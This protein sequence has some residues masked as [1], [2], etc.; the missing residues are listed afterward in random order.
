MPEDSTQKPTPPSSSS[1]TETETPAT[2]ATPAIPTAEAAAA[3]AST[4]P[5]AAAE[6]V[7]PEGHLVNREFSV[8]WKGIDELLEAV[9]SEVF[10]TVPA[11][12][13]RI[14]TEERQDGDSDILLL[15]HTGGKWREL[16]RGKTIAETWRRLVTTR[17]PA[18]QIHRDRKRAQ[19]EQLAELQTPEPPADIPQ[20][21]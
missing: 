14:I 18:A 3:P 21:P 11:D 16:S 20:K 2:P 6:A 19:L 13:L 10:P 17:Q 9:C 4:P 12:A 7:T 5:A 8:G 15:R 1:A